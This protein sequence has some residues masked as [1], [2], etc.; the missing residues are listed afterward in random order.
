MCTFDVISKNQK[1]V[2]N[3]EISGWGRVLLPILPTLIKWEFNF[4]NWFVIII[5]TVPIQAKVM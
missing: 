1:P 4:V 2:F 3:L 5:L